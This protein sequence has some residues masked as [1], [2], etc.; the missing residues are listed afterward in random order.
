MGLPHAQARPQP[1][2][3]RVCLRREVARTGH[4]TSLARLALAFEVTREEAKLMKGLWVP[5]GALVVLAMA[6]CSKSDTAPSPTPG[7][8]TATVSSVLVSGAA[9]SATSYQLTASAR[10]SDGSSKDVTTTSQWQSSNEALAKVSPAGV[11]TVVGTGKVM[12]RAVYQ[13]VT[14]T[15]EMNVTM[16]AGPT[17]FALG[18]F[19][20]EAAP[21]S[22][23]LEGVKVSITAGP[24]AGQFTYTN[25]TG[26]FKFGSLKAGALALSIDRPNYVPWTYNITLD[27]DVD[28]PIVL[29]PR[30]PTNSS[31]AVATARCKDGSWTWA[32][33]LAGACT[34]Q[35][36]VAYTVCP[37]KLCAQLR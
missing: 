36:G 4:G 7:T 14:G 10:L 6:A 1:W 18:G 20:S 13:N 5:V 37:G 23:V 11:L 17:T 8:S 31:G 9:T 30:P 24:D 27:R 15:L 2:R 19:V 3:L 26:I 34:A 21:V 32:D 33:T 28:L 29:Y 25:E 22:K 16:L 35:G 12:V